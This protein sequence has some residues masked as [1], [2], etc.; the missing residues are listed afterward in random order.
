MPGRSVLAQDPMLPLQAIRGQRTSARIRN[1]RNRIRTCAYRSPICA[2]SP[3]LQAVNSLVEHEETD[4]HENGRNQH[5]MPAFHPFLEPGEHGIEPIT[6]HCVRE[7]RQCDRRRGGG[8][9]V[10][11]CRPDP[12]LTETGAADRQSRLPRR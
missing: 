8:N 7:D 5:G 2:E 12:G 3:D 11:P 6:R 10:E 9:E 4:H 1:H